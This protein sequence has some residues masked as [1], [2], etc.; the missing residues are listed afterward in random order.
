MLIVLAVVAVFGRSVGFAFVTL[1]DEALVSADPRLN[2]FTAASLAA[3]WAGPYQS[4]Y[5]PATY[6][7]WGLLTFVARVPAAAGRPTLDPAVFH[8]A[9]VALHAA[10]AVLVW[11]I[12]RRTRARHGPGRCGG[13]RVRPAPGA[14]RAGGVGVGL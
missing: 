9:N 3:F 7:A 2:P 10:N 11:L 5:I 1:D 12:L 14:G 13:A 8:A 6:T 4:L